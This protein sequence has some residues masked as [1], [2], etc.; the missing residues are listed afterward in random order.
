[1]RKLY[2]KKK[3]ERD[4]RKIKET[5]EK[6]R[7]ERRARTRPLNLTTEQLCVVCSTNPKEVSVLKRVNYSI[8]LGV[9]PFYLNYLI[10]NIVERV[11]VIVFFLQII[12]LPCGHVCI[13]EDCSE[14]IRVT[15]P[16]CRGKIATK[17]AAFI[18]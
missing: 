11:V 7:R 16:V 4:E 8:G 12:I 13:C 9:M 17:A 2:N 6:E 3:Q 18:A 5:L 1:M 15:C 14:K 10:N